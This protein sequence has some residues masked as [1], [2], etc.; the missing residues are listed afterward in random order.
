VIFV[1]WIYLKGGRRVAVWSHRRRRPE[2]DRIWRAIVDEVR[3]AA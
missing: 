1:R 2:A 3:R